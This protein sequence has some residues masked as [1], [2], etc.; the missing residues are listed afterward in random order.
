VSY[1]IYSSTD[2]YGTFAY[3]ATTSQ[4]SWLV[5]STEPKKFYYVVAKDS[6]KKKAPE[7]ITVKE[8]K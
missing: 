5:V 6:A 1:D 2:P 8:K 4:T 7:T 3:T